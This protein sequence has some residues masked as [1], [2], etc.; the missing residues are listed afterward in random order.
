[1]HSCP[2]PSRHPCA[3][4][5]RDWQHRVAGTSWRLRMGLPRLARGSAGRGRRPLKSHGSGAGVKLVRNLRV[6]LLSGARHGLDAAPVHRMQAPPHGAGV[7]RNV[8][9]QVPALPTGF[10]TNAHP[11]RGPSRAPPLQAFHRLASIVPPLSAFLSPAVDVYCRA[12][13]ARRRPKLLML[14]AHAPLAASSSPPAQPHQRR[15]SSLLVVLVPQRQS[16]TTFRSRSWSPGCPRIR[17]RPSC[18]GPSL[19]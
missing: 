18:T 15:R 3:D 2:T 13:Q 12:A 4:E 10:G 16:G 1:M 19:R 7:A 14:R 11:S 5:H 8:H 6:Q 17:R 9:L